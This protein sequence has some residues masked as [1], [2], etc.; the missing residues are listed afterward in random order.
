MIS[1]AISNFYN[2]CFLKNCILQQ[3][4]NFSFFWFRRGLGAEEFPQGG[5]V[6]FLIHR[7]GQTMAGSG[8]SYQL[9]PG[10]AGFKAQ[11]AHV[12]GNK[13]VILAMEENHRHRAVFQSLYGRSFF[14]IK[15]TEEFGT[16]FYKGV[17]KSGGIPI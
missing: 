2:L 17:A 1:T 11:A 13:V 12:T 8:D 10:R 4:L 3:S 6:A 15:M 7:E 16:Q 5:N 9:L 14:Q